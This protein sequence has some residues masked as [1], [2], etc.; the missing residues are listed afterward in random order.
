ME[1]TDL[2]KIAARYPGA[3]HALVK[4]LDATHPMPAAINAAML[5]TESGR[6]EIA[7]QQGRRQIISELQ[8]ALQQVSTDPKVQEAVHDER[9][10][11]G[12]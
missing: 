2:C 3:I 11:A 6:L 5:A 7:E 12:G 4:Y 9:V 10:F 8:T 1:D